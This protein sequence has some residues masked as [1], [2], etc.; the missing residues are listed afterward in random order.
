VS[1]YHTE[2]LTFEVVHF[3]EPYHVILGKPCYVKFMAIPNY[4]YLKHKILGL[5]D[6]ITVEAKAQW[7]LD[8][9]QN[10]IDLVAA[11]EL[12]L[13]A[14]PSLA[15]PTMPTTSGTF[16]AAEDA[17][18]IQIDIYYPPKTIQIGVSFVRHNKDIFV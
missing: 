7:A 10:S 9:E 11:M 5:I 15:N 8:Y 13:N 14:P 2:T 6:I 18:A 17:K 1:N 12:C 16:K 3:S 4:A